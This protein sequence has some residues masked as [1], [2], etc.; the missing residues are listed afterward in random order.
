M[1]ELIVKTTLPALEANFDIVKQQLIDGLKTYDVII[2]AETVKDGKTMASEINKIKKAIKD[3][4]KKALEDIMGPVD[5]FKNKI[6]E[7]MDLADEARDK[8]TAQVAAYEEKTKLEIQKKI[9]TFVFDEREKAELREPFS[10]IDAQDLVKL[11][12]V[13]KT[14]NLTTATMNMIKGRVAEQKN[15]QL[16]DDV[17]IAQEAKDKEDEI[18]RIREEERIKAEAN[19]KVH[20]TVDPQPQQMQQ[21]PSNETVQD[22]GFEYPTEEPYDYN[23]DTGEVYPE[24][25]PAFMD[26]P[27]EETMSPTPMS[28]TSP[29]RTVKVLIDIEVDISKIPTITD[30]QIVDAL[31]RK[32]KTA[33]INNAQIRDLHRF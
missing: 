6:Q 30:Q 27:R 24:E 17:R 7:L 9:D 29:K 14:G 2:T 32:L 31:D 5:G 4:Q 28:D 21:A 33:G 19:I 20:V 26:N 15:L 25:V 12:A 22:N 10:K 18:A 23:P 16:E 1:Q 11:G 3:Q 13:T 8:I